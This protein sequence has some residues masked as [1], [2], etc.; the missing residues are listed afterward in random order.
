MG[1]KL[2]PSEQSVSVEG[3]SLVRASK[4]T[5]VSQKA[6]CVSIVSQC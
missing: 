3:Q 4:T 1:D 5:P 2:A 6:L